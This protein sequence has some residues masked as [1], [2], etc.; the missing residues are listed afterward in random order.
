MT[1]ASK[2]ERLGTEKVGNLLW[3]MS[4]QTTL[5]LLVYAIYSVTDTYFLSVGINSLA[6]AGSSVVSPVLIALGGLATTVGTGAGRAQPAEG[7]AEGC[8]YLPDLLGCGD[9]NH[10]VWGVVRRAHRLSVRGNRQRGA[11]CD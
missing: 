5:S 4:S 6:A 9:R 8:Q 1:N 11:L 2:A 10:G 7:F 3:E